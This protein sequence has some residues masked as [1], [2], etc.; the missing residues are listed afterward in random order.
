MERA[1][2]RTCLTVRR[3]SRHPVIQRSLRSSTF[4]KK[5]VIRATALSF[6]PDTANDV[7]F[8]KAQLNMDEFVHAASDTLTIA[9]MSTLAA[10]LLTL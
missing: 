1:V 2:K 7:I 8:H 5:H 10:I 9:A 6:I 4:L 3:A